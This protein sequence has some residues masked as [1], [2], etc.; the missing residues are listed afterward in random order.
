MFSG[1][2]G[3]GGSPQR[4]LNSSRSKSGKRGIRNTLLEDNPGFV[5]NAKVQGNIVRRGE[6]GG[7]VGRDRAGSPS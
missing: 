2:G 4:T 7:G 1:G 3:Y 6:G 5:D